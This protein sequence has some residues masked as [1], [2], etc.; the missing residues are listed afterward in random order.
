MARCQAHFQMVDV[1]DGAVLTM[2]TTWPVVMSVELGH[3]SAR[4][5]VLCSRKA[6]GG[7]GWLSRC[8]PHSSVCTFME[9]PLPLTFG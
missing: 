3:V 5:D 1:R 9:V 8:W 2:M 6:P 4:L 7:L